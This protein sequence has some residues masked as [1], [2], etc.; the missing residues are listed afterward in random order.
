M[1]ARIKKSILFLIFTLSLPFCLSAQTNNPPDNG[2]IG[3]VINTGSVAQVK[4][5]DLS[6]N[7]FS[8][9]LNSYFASKVG[10]GTASILATLDVNPTITAATDLRNIKSGLV[11]NGGSTMANYYGTYIAA[12]TGSGTITNKY[13]L[14]T[15]PNAGKVGIGTVAPASALSVNGSIQMSDDTS[16]CTT[17]NVGTF[18]WHSSALEVCSGTAWTSA[19]AP[20]TAPICASGTLCGLI[21]Y[22]LTTAYFQPAWDNG[23]TGAAYVGYECVTSFAP[24]NPPVNSSCP[25]NYS[26]LWRAYPNNGSSY[27]SAPIP[28]SI[29]AYCDVGYSYEELDRRD[30]TASGGITKYEIILGACRKQ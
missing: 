22:R 25:S 15:E 3:T 2:T 1:N 26:E 30:L 13:A 9:V 17:A 11:Y 27:N 18:R 29:P 10:I 14:V 21:Y 24:A 6:V 16:A 8:A 28:T 23:R 5:G 12:P 19:G 7:A 4:N 20:T